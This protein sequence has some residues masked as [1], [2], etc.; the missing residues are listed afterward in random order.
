[1]KLKLTQPLLVRHPVH[2]HLDE[3]AHVL[4]LI[5]LLDSLLRSPC[6]GK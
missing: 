4:L 1:M 5:E 6:V 3:E 2:L